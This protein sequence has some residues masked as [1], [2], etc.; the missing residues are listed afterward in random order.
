MVYLKR[1]HFRLPSKKWI[2]GLFEAAKLSFYT[3][4][5]FARAGRLLTVSV[6]FYFTY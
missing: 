1:P 5:I 6:N 2:N 4:L 3:P